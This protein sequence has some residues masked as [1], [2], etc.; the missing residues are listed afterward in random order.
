MT[1]RVGP[2]QIVREIGRGGMAVVYLARQPALARAVALKELSPFHV[3]D[4][5]LAR[6][7]LR[8]AQMAGS[9]SHPNVVTVFDF[10]EQDGTPYIAMEYLDRG[11]LRPSIGKLSV[12]QAAG[13]ARRAAGG[14]VARGDEAHRAPRREAGEPARD[15]R[16]RDQDRRLRHRQGLPAGGHGRDADAGGRDRRH[17]VVHGARTGD[18]AGDRAVD[19]PLRDRR[20]RL[21]TAGRSRAVPRR[22]RADGGDPPARQRPGPA[23][24]GR[25]RSRAGGLGAPPAGQGPGGATGDR[26]RGVGVAGGDHRRR[27]SARCGAATRRWASVDPTVEHALPPAR[28]SSWQDYVP[29]DVA[30]RPAPPPPTPTPPRSRPP[31]PRRR[32]CRRQRRASNPRPP[33]RRRRAQ[34]PREQPAATPPPPRKRRASSPPPPRRRQRP[35]KRRPSN[36]PPADAA[37]CHAAAARRK[38]RASNPRPPPAARATQRRASP[39]P[40]QRTGRRASRPRPPLRRR[41]RT[42]ARAARRRR[43]AAGGGPAAKRRLPP[44]RRRRRVRSRRPSRRP[45]SHCIGR[46][47]VRRSSWRPCSRSSPWWPPWCSCPATATI[48]R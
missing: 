7:F 3:R 42:A 45:R 26:A 1:E 16:R 32:P 44:R 18:G 15:R 4:E 22:R 17:A 21:R 41:P 29:S 14:A 40:T 25:H 9:L 27:G 19:R 38:R 20:R 36:R 13:R 39:P 8:E 46:A 47:G 10:I 28:F 6:R 43:A 5:S 35:R 31:P 33:R 11:S 37:R 34:A 2:Y 24:A 23:D 48:R 12:A 30:A